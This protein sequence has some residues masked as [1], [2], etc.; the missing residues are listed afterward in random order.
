MFIL[1]DREYKDL[2]QGQRYLRDLVER[3]EIPV[4]DEIPVAVESVAAILNEKPRADKKLRFLTRS[5]RWV[6]CASNR[7]KLKIRSNTIS[8]PTISSE[9]R[10]TSLSFKDA[11]KDVYLGGS[12]VSDWRETLAIPMLK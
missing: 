2:V 9:E 10:R 12:D 5:V 8:L 6:R 7:I 4:F 3:Y 1:G 11:H